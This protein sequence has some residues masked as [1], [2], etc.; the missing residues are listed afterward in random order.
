MP[1]KP[2]KV[3]SYC[4]HKH[5][6]RA[7]VRIDGRDHYLGLFGSPASHKRYEQLVAEWRASQRPVGFP[8]GKIGNS[9]PTYSVNEFILQY[10]KHV[11]SYYVKRGRP[12]DEQ[13]GIRAALRFVRRLFGRT[14]ATEFGPLRLK[15]VRGAMIEAGLSRGVINQY[16]R[17]VRRMFRWGVENELIPV[18]VYQSLL[19][20]TGLAKGR[21]K[22]RET[23]PVGPVKDEHVAAIL[24][25]LTIVVRS[26]VRLQRLSG[27]RPQDVC[28]IRPCDVE[29]SG[30]VWCW[31]PPTHKTEHNGH[32]RRIYIGPRAQAV[33]R[34]WLDRASAA[35]CF[36]P[37]E[38]T[39]VSFA[40]RRGKTGNVANRSHSRRKQEGNRAPGDHYT[41]FSFRQ[42]IHRAC[43]RAGVP[44]WNPNQLRH[45]RG[46]EVRKNH[47]LEAAQT[48]LGHQRA[49]VTQVYAE[50]NE[51][52]ACKIAKKTG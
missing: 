12:T 15:T 35:Y 36:S 44:R 14:P 46:T 41:R 7:V 29:T 22:A 48:V 10:W 42:A 32:Q 11:Q 51:E 34:P 19:T 24:P 39:E 47:G 50:R 23:E 27:C 38:S 28:N 3:P 2:G 37:R 43:D 25:H 45:S 4:L 16:V 21:S 1:R 9:V 33:L 30:D 5:S 17:R 6:G 8:A 52:L 31:T 18:E 13:A 26:M 49:D 40:K 20:V